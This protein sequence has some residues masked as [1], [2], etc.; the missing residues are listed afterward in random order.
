MAD[1]LATLFGPMPYEIDAARRQQDEAYATKMAGMNNI[2]QAK[3]GIGQGAAGIARGVGGMFGLVDPAVEAE[4]ARTAALSNVD[5]NDW[6]SL[7]EAAIRTQDPRLKMQL[8][9]LAQQR[10]AAES[11]SALEQAQTYAQLRKAQMEASPLAKIDPSK[12]TPESVKAWFESGMKN[13]SLL[14]AIEKTEKDPNS[15]REWVLAGKPGTYEGFLMRGKKASGTTVT[16]IVGG[17]DL[18]DIPKFRKDVQETIKPQLETIYAADKAMTALDLAMKGNPSAFQAART[19]AAKTAG[20]SQISLREIEAAGGDPSII[21][22]LSDTTSVLFT[23]TPTMDTMRD[24]KRT[25]DAIR[26]VAKQKG[27]SEIATQREMGLTSGYSK[28]NLDKAL[29]FD[30]FDA[31]EINV[32]QTV[33]LKSGKKVTRED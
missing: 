26:K 21:G 16:N 32:G 7:A 14:E 22:K 20:D 27:Q 30:A 19:M 24:M 29:R 1:S 18:K 15:Y 17:K 28:E 33:T 5:P 4:K 6:R 2:Q 25:M 12:Y 3:L 31:K 13:P 9:M 23:G 8:G 10:K 11:K